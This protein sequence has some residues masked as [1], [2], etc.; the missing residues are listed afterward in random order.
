MTAATLRNYTCKDLARM[1]KE[2]GISGWHAMRKDELVTALVK[3]ARR[4]SSAKR[5]S[6]KRAPDDKNGSARGQATPRPPLEKPR[7]SPRTKKRIMQL[8]SKLERVKNLA[9]DPREAA[10]SQDRLVVMVRDPYWLHAYWELGQQSVERARV[11]L[12]QAWHGAKAVLR[13]Y[14]V[15][16]DGNSSVIRDIE[17]HGGVRNWYVDVQDPPQSFRLEIGYRALDGSFYCLARSNTVTTPPAVTS[18][19]LDD[20]WVDVAENADRIY[21]MSGGYSPQG[22]ARNCRSCLKNV[23]AGRWGPRCRRGLVMV[24][25]EENIPNSSSPSMQN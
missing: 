17:I 8:Q 3:V 9:S 11:A 15:A 5:A 20:N 6:T 4:K 24:P 12:S 10:N 2:H 25:D 1:A 22:Q 23:S 19:A 21:A 16:D 14:N 7:T 13:L 18:D